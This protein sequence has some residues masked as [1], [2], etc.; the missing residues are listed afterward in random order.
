MARR[1]AAAAA[2]PGRN[3]QTRPIFTVNLNGE[4]PRYQYSWV[5]V[6]KEELYSM[7]LNSGAEK[8]PAPTGSAEADAKEQSRQAIWRMVK[9]SATRKLSLHREAGSILLYCRK[10]G[11]PGTP[12]R[13][14]ARPAKWA[15]RSSCSS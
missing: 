11:G 15:R 13:L 10:I 9:D 14:A 2:D 6:G 3:R 12:A 7:Q 5:E 1:Q 8:T 4:T